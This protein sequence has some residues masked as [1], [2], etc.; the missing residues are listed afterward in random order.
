MQE[1]DR[2]SL[3]LLRLEGEHGRFQ[4]RLVERPQR[5]AFRADALVDLGAAL[6]RN[7]RRGLAHVVVVDGWPGLAPEFQHVAE[8]L[9]RQQAGARAPALDDDVGRDGRAMAEIA[10]LRAVDAGIGHELPQPGLDGLGGIARR[11][12]HLEEADRAV[13]LVHQDEVG[14]RATDVDT[15]SHHWVIPPPEPILQVPYS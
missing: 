15:D 3:D 2:D 6:A 7:Q 14:E 8:P 1:A 4:R 11:G 9:G 13:I 12:G 10:D 5:R